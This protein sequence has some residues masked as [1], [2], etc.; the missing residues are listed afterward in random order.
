MTRRVVREEPAASSI[1]PAAPPWLAG[2]ALVLMPLIAYV[3]A[4]RAL[5][6]WD[7]D[8]YLTQNPV[9]RSPSGLAD[10]WLRPT[11]NP[12]YYPLVFTTFWIEARLWKL[13]PVG[14]HVVNVLLHA[15][16]AVVV[17]RVLRRLELPGAW[18]AAA[19]FAL[20]P[21]NVESV[22][23]I[24]ERK[25]VLSG[26]FYLLALSAYLRFEPLD[27]ASLVR[28]WGWYAVSL[29]CFAL[30]LTAKTVTCSLPAAIL[31]LIWWK[32]GR[33]RLREAAALAPFFALGLA[34]AFVT[35]WVERHHVLTR[36]VPF[37]LSP[38][39]R[40]LIAGRA[41][42]FYLYKLL[43]PIQQTFI[44]ERWSIDPRAAWQYAYPAAAALIVA[45]LWLARS[46]VGR[47][48]LTAALLFVGT[49]VPALGFVDVYPMRY[50]FVADHFAY[51][52]G[53]AVFAAIAWLLCR[54]PFAS[55]PGGRVGA[56]ALLAVLGAL[57]WRHAIHFRDAETL[58]RDTL[59][60]NPSAWIAC[61]NLGGILLARG[62]LDGAER[63][64]HESLRLNPAS[65]R[66]LNNLA[67][68][69]LLRQ[70]FESAAAL[71]EQ[72]IA[73][74][75]GD[76]VE[77]HYTLGQALLSQRHIDEAIVHFRK[78]TELSGGALQPLMG[79]SEALFAAGRYAECEAALRALL[80]I[81]PANE[82]G[83]ELLQALA[84]RRS[85]VR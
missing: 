65:A 8:F 21:V 66:T 9:I 73:I 13:D 28:R 37:A 31:L 45:A 19:I 48:P 55:Q 22:A 24:T 3:P 35:A 56:V 27:V 16:S 34:L 54:M 12:Q 39:E 67:S 72:A 76:H 49:L 78:S 20:H 85:S 41:V 59:A 82:H 70:R 38:I 60:K 1:A 53:A 33:V 52:A 83:N 81:D 61:N 23:W 79:L 2:V 7:D 47:G 44:Y 69:E 11:A 64:F 74:P 15:A 80:R 10:S 29:A 42:W 62:D 5:Y 40:L 57:S 30:A 14:F 84:A 43:V 26:L 58:W 46:S 50:S 77:A 18:L 17:W 63:L 4:Y 6:V 75:G 68:I 32:R 25:N 51:L 71:A 36:E